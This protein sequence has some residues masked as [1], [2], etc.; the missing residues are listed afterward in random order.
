MTR[1][2]PPHPS[3]TCSWASRA[4]RRRSSRASCMRVEQAGV[5][6][7]P[8]RHQARRGARARASPPGR[9]RDPR[10]SRSYLPDA[11]SLT[12][13]L[14]RWRPRAP[15][16]RSPRR[17]G[18]RCGAGPR[19]LARA[20]A[21][22]ARPGA[23]A[24]AARRSPAR[25]RSTSRSSCRRSRWPTGCSPRPT[26]ATCTRTSRTARR[27]SRWLAARI[28]G[29]PFSFTGH[30]RDIYAPRAEPA[31]AGCAASC[32]P[33][34]FAVTCTEA[35]VAPPAAGSRPRRDVH[36]V[37]H[38]L[39]ADF[40]RL[41]ARSRA[42]AARQ[43]HAARPRRRPARGQEGLRRARRGVRACC[44]RRGVAVRGR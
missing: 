31:A 27:R 43:R 25:A 24:T 28:T 42:P 16:S 44:D 36:L 14:H 38:G 34:S 30:A 26:S 29:L 19:G 15:A 41:L 20:A 4:S 22:R 7:A 17:S 18:A 12:A 8:V 23:C 10:R 35:N 6:R 32:S 37:Y 5:P 1:P 40:A 21:T 39:N 11:S 33:P 13:P 9:R 3:A 2:H